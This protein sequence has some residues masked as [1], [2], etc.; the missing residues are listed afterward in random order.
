MKHM[1]QPLGSSL[2]GQTCVAMIA[3]VSIEESIAAFGGTRGGTRTRQLVDAL[4]KLGIRCGEPPL[5]R[6]DGDCFIS[7]T[8]IVKLH[9]EWTKRTHWVVWHEGRY[10]DPSEYG[11]MLLL[12]PNNYEY[13]EGVRSTSYLPIYLP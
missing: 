6:I 2:C 1:F 13:A 12:K 11:H 9:F 8:C 4:H 3:G 5:I 10:Y 7:D